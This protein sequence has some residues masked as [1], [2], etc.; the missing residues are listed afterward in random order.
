L[1]LR[2][3]AK[4]SYLR[5]LKAAKG[6]LLDF[7]QF[8]HIEVTNYCN[9]NCRMCPYTIMVSKNI[10]PQ[11]N[12]SF[13]FFKKI[14][15]ECKNFK[16][17]VE[18]VAL[19]GIGEPFINPELIKMSKYAKECGLTHIYTSTNAHFIDKEMAYR[20]VRESGFDTLIIS[21][22][23]VSK[24]T[25]EAVR[26][27]GDFKKVVDNL[28]NLFKVRRSLGVS[29]PRLVVEILCMQETQR[30]IG[31][32]TRFWRKFLCYK[33]VITVRDVDRFGGLVDIKIEKTY[34]HRTPCAQ[35]WRDFAI[36]WD[37]KVT[38]CC[39]DAFWSMTV[40]D[41]SSDSILKIWHSDNWNLIRQLH[42]RRE[43]DK[44]QICKNCTEWDQ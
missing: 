24:S 18:K 4:R 6:G 39:K 35:L 31:N 1:P 28:T 17:I 41:V 2:E 5:F 21:I 40:G 9:L 25:Y 27:K 7:P 16:N 43:F 8:I 30:E 29:R 42:L 22:D 26:V 19:M 3:V 10:R 11:G 36:S 12:M 14:V 32:F 13:D 33:D 23:G 38:V 34:R 15:D 44:L 37:G 20:L